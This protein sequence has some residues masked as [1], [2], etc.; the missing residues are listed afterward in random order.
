MSRSAMR[1]V[2]SAV[3]LAAV[4]LPHASAAAPSASTRGTNVLT[5][6]GWNQ[7][8]GEGHTLN[9]FRS[10]GISLTTPG[11]PDHLA[12]VECAGTVESL[13]DKSFRANGYCVLTDVDGDKWLDRWWADSSMPKGRWEDTGISG[14]WKDLRRTGTYA[15][16]DRSPTGGCLGVSTWE[17]DER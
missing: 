14:K 17:T 8:L 7:S 15:Y 10:R 6:E 16:Q 5:C 13:P 9:L 1:Y 12:L 3:T 4:S 2:F 11:S